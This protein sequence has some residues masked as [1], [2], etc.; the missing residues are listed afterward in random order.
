MALTEN[1]IN[2]HCGL[3]VNDTD[4]WTITKDEILQVNL[5]AVRDLKKLGLLSVLTEGNGCNAFY[6][7]DTAGLV[8]GNAT[9]GWYEG[10]TN[11]TPKALGP[12]AQP[13]GSELH[14]NHIWTVPE[15]EYIVQEVRRSGLNEAVGSIFLHD[16]T[17]TQEAEVVRISEWLLKNAPDIIPQVQR[18]NQNPDPNDGVRCLG[19]PADG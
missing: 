10:T 2:V 17:V 7:N 14:M 8:F 13:T 5:E 6:S 12:V 3:H 15:V 19:E 9:G 4:G 1:A 18:T 16:D 11:V